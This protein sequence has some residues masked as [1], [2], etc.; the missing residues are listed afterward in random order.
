MPDI[1]RI[2]GEL[3]DTYCKAVGG[4]AFNGDP[5]PNWDEFGKDPNKQKQADAWREVAMKALD[6]C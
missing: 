5:L 2:A 6:I 3:Y 4:Q 1:N